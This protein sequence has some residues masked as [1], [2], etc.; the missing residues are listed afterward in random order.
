MPEP[1]KSVTNVW[2]REGVLESLSLTKA[3]FDKALMEAIQKDG[4]KDCSGTW[5]YSLP[6]SLAGRRYRLHEVAHIKSN[7]GL[8]PQRKSEPG[9]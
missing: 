7:H 9:A 5:I 2:P 3:D 6:I 4:W 8:H 1:P